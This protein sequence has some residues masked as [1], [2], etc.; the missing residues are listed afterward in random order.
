VILSLYKLKDNNDYSSY[1]LPLNNE[2]PFIQVRIY[3]R[4]YGLLIFRLSFP[5]KDLCVSSKCCKV[6]LCP[7]YSIAL[8]LKFYR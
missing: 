4:Y 8:M 6:S 5:L 1:M 3:F 2:C 7:Q